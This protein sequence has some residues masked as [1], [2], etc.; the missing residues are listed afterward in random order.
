MK[1]RSCVSIAVL[2]C[3]LVSGNSSAESSVMENGVSLYLNA[4]HALSEAAICHAGSV[5]VD[6]IAG[7]RLRGDTRAQIDETFGP[8]LPA[9]MVNLIDKGFSYDPPSLRDSTDYYERCTKIAVEKLRRFN[10]AMAR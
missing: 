6:R 3:A 1:A 10:P 8:N 5:V 2:M 9:V 4:E 7:A